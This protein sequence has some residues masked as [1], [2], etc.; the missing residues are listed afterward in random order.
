MVFGPKLVYNSFLLTA[1]CF[2]DALSLKIFSLC[3][4]DTRLLK[5]GN[6]HFVTLHNYY[7]IL[8]SQYFEFNQDLLQKDCFRVSGHKAEKLDEICMRVSVLTK[9]STLTRDFHP[10]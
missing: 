7:Q 10:I 6:F 1:N 4:R 8:S 9:L 5:V 3:F 2:L